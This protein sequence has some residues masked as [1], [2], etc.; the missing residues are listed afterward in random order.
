MIQAV[1]WKRRLDIMSPAEAEHIHQASL[2]I[3]DRTGLLM[4]LSP[5]KL[6]KAQ[7]LGLRFDKN[8]GRLHFP[9][10]VVEKALKSAPSSYTLYARSEENHMPINGQFGYLTT[11]GCATKVLDINTH[12]VR[13]STMQDLADLAVVADYIPQISFFW[14][15]VSAQDAP[16]LI[17]PLYELKTILLNSSKHIQAMTAVDPLNAQGTVDICRSIM[18]GAEALRQKPIISNFQCS[19]SPLSYDEKGLEAAFIFAEAGV[20]TGFLNMQIGCST[21]P[22]TLAGNLAMGNAEI[23]AGIVVLQL[24]YPGAP[25][26]YG[27]CATTM[28]LK[29]GGCTCGGPDD[30]LLQALSA[31]MA[32]FYNLPSNIGTFA[33]G[34]KA[35]DWHCGVENTL[36]GTMSMLANA[37]MMCGAGLACSASIFS[38]E[39]MVLDCENFDVIQETLKGITINEE[40]LALDVIDA[41]GPNNHFMLEEHTIDHMHELWQPQIM[42]R[43]SYE[44]WEAKG[45]KTAQD[46]ANEKIRHILS[47]HKPV[48]EQNTSDIDTIIQEYEARIL[49]GSHK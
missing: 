12:Q 34:A 48:I 22:A 26:F 41:V 25:T 3:M 8:T 14:P 13:N 15:S 11:D 21:A 43:G 39:Q 20:P 49:S 29:M 32:R 30:V 40:T 10:H 37:D 16:P 47:T 46:V 7:D 31:Q 35:S 36:S 1:Q 38:L 42:H 28:E 19:I 5:S 44:D 4:P 33:T 17:Q 6:E 9:G 45:R 2:K 23:L 24:L 27:S 18:G